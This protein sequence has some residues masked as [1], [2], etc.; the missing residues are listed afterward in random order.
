MN[1]VC[2]GAPSDAGTRRTST[3]RPLAVSVRSSGWLPYPVLDAETWTS[4]VESASR[5]SPA[6]IATTSR[7]RV[8]TGVPTPTVNTGAAAPSTRASSLAVVS[9]P[10]EMT[11]MPPRARPR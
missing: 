4:T 3:G 7:S 5:G 2:T 8:M 11:T 1:T 6:V 9:P 10:S